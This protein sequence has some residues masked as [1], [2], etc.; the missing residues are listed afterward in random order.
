M[1]EAKSGFS[2][3]MTL[4]SREKIM[5]MTLLLALLCVVYYRVFF[6]KSARELKDVIDEIEYTTEKI[7][8]IEAGY[9][10]VAKEKAEVDRLKSEYNSL[11][12]TL[13]GFESELLD[14]TEIPELLNTIM[15]E[16]SVSGVA[17]DSAKPEEEEYITASGEVKKLEEIL[18]EEKKSAKKKEI[19][20]T[21]E[22]E[23]MAIDEAETLYKILPISINFKSSFNQA[24]SYIRKVEDISSYLQV[25]K[26]RMLIDQQKGT[27][28]E[29]NMITSILLGRGK[30]GSIEEL[31]EAKASL[32][33]MERLME[34]NPFKVE[35]MPLEKGELRDVTLGGIIKRRNQPYAMLNDSLY[36]IG[37]LF[38]G[39]E[40]V[41]IDDSEVT[42]E[43]EGKVYQLS[44][45][46]GLGG[47]E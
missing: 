12:K 33:E 46:I 18:A 41:K 10:D 15:K 38:Q 5:L 36:T 20:P 4:G 9:P 30:G 22:T 26:L 13:V 28:P 21:A 16:A 35:G 1:K 7:E 25:S 24:I 3:K 19:E 31:E 45:S 14:E 37:D 44:I 43:G 17:F 47:E 32:K 6:I 27:N 11:S 2:F 34:V 39:K 23:E 29:V 40:I 8:K 42:L